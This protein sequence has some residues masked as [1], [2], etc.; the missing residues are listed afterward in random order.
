MTFFV[1]TQKINFFFESDFVKLHGHGLLALTQALASENSVFLINHGCCGRSRPGQIDQGIS[2]SRQ[3]Q[4]R[5]CVSCTSPRTEATR[6]SQRLPR[7]N[8]KEAALCG[9]WAPAEKL[10]ESSSSLSLPS[11]SCRRRTQGVSTG[12]ALWGPARNLHHK[13]QRGR[14]SWALLGVV[15]QKIPY[16]ETPPRHPFLLCLCVFV[17]HSH[18]RNKKASYSLFKEEVVFCWGKDATAWAKVRGF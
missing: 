7:P 11:W 15:W 17:H 3:A 1:F 2:A 16:A 8:Q 4:V 18:N 5:P 10:A 14:P 6:R 13:R 12:A 9:P